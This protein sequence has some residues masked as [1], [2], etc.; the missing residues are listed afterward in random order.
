MLYSNWR[1]ASKG[2]ASHVRDCHKNSCA[3]FCRD[4]PETCNHLVGKTERGINK[5]LPTALSKQQKDTLPQ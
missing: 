4:C 1:L 2:G 3:D 5:L